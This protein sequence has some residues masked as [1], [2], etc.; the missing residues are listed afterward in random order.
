M[1]VAVE[2]DQFQR[3]YEIALTGLTNCMFLAYYCLVNRLVMVSFIN[4]YVIISKYL[5]S[6]DSGLESN[7]LQ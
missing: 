1:A 6:I 3:Y 2:I 4:A 5:F 7:T